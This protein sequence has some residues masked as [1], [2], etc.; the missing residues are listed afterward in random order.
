MPLFRN[1]DAAVKSKFAGLTVQSA[2]L[3]SP[4]NVV[5]RYQGP[6]NEYADATY[7]LILIQRVDVAF[8]KDRAVQGYAPL[9]YAPEGY[10]SY[11][12]A[13]DPAKSPYWTNMPTPVYLD[14]VVTL[15]CRRAEHQ[16]ELLAT[17]AGFDYCDAR[18][19]YLIVP[20]DNTVRRF[21]VLG[22]PETDTARDELGKR[23]LRA[24]WRLRTAGELI[25]APIETPAKTTAVDLT[26]QPTTAGT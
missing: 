15:L 5:V 12:G 22:G 14:Y 26:V 4:T 6:E 10:Q 7:P 13:P 17:L 3:S 8:A 25:W 11:T 18:Y 24:T 9:N 1:E 2:A 21:D 16:T 23:L 20:A 19:G